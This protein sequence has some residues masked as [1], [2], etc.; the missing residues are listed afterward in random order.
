MVGNCWFVV[1][2]LIVLCGCVCVWLVGCW[3]VLCGAGCLLLLVICVCV[4]YCLLVVLCVVV[5]DWFLVACLY[6]LYLLV[7]VVLFGCVGLLVC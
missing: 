2:Y 5:F 1:G 3:F 6:W 7:M 4:V